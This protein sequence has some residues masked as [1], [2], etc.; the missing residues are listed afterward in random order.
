[1]ATPGNKDKNS[2]VLKILAGLKASPMPAEE[3]EQAAADESW[4]AS[5]APA[6]QEAQPT[7]EPLMGMPELSA[8]E[9]AKLNR[10]R[11]QRGVPRAPIK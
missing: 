9:T 4:L 3:D 8:T 11:A 5:G 10:R 6:D 2:R 7:E 1:M